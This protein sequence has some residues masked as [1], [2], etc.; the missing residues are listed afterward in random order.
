M[1][2][3]NNNNLISKENLLLI[4]LKEWKYP[5]KNE[6]RY[7]FNAKNYKSEGKM[8]SSAKD[9]DLKDV[10]IFFTSDLK[11]VVYATA[12]S[13]IDKKSAEAE[14]ICIVEKL[15]TEAIKKNSNKE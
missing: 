2:Q 8:I 15:I 4:G 1:E 13:G 6:V 5:T 3:E 7:Y 11:L 10:K 12:E 14:I 9:N